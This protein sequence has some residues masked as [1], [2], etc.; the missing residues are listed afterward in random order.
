MNAAQSPAQIRN[1]DFLL[2]QSSGGGAGAGRNLPLSRSASITVTGGRPP[3]SLNT[4][5]NAGVGAFTAGQ[6]A[7]GVGRFLRKK[8][9]G[10]GVTPEGGELP[11]DMEEILGQD[12][13]E[14][15]E[16]PVQP[17]PPGIADLDAAPDPVRLA[18][19]RITPAPETGIAQ[20]SGRVPATSEVTDPVERGFLSVQE[21]IHTGV[22]QSE[23]GLQGTS[24]ITQTGDNI[25]RIG[26]RVA[27]TRQVGS[28]IVHRGGQ[29]TRDVRPGATRMNPDQWRSNILDQTETAGNPFRPA[30]QPG[31]RGTMNPEL[32]GGETTAEAVAPEVGEA[33][34]G[35]AE[36]VPVAT[37]AALGVGEAAVGAEAVAD[38]A[39]VALPLLGAALL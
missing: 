27:P 3:S 16:G 8:F 2:A 12:P 11:E 17:A 28:Q 20:V 21:G 4:L 1:V 38:V 25:Y 19:A 29:F 6:T 14:P 13:V 34:A 9:G 35:A 22:R 37:E 36:A 5:A 33:A 24:R 18:T 32:L 39:A 10:K 26:T 7:L 31:I 23:T 15:A 30:S